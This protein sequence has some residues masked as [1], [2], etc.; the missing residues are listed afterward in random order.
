MKQK[1]VL[2]VV[3]SALLGMSAGNADAQGF[4]P[5]EWWQFRSGLFA[6]DYITPS[7][8]EPGYLTGNASSARASRNGKL[9]FAAA[10]VD[11]R[12]QQDGSPKVTVLDAPRVGR[13]TT[14]LGQFVA[15]DNDGGS[16]ICLGRTVR[17]TRVFY[18]GRATSGDRIV[19]RV[20]YPTKG[21]IYDHV[22]SVR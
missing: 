22:V 21:L 7:Y 6:P 20:A 5:R 10:S 1:F 18:Q 2:V 13:V 16:K 4:Y 8:D 17:G 12:C 9:V 3:T 14:D 15:V 11:Q 19:L